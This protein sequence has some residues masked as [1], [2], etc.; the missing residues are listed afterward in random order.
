MRLILLFSGIV[1]TSPAWAAE[2][3]EC[4]QLPKPAV[5]LKLIESPI[6]INIDYGY[7]SLTTLGGEKVKPG[8]QVLGLTRINTVAHYALS[9]PAYL[10]SSRAY[11]CASPQ[12]AVTLGFNQMTVYVGKEFPKGSCAYNEIFEHEMRHVKTYQEHFASI[13]KGIQEEISRRFATGSIWRGQAGSSAARV[14]KELDERW[15]P[16]INR[17]IKK[18]ELAQ[19]LIDTPE[20]Y[21]RL[22]KAC[23]GEVQKLAK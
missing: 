14:G 3:N 1:A 8:G 7:R 15:L 16:Y 4:E 12:I 13:E 22:S 23:N 18:V 6:S 11:E 2:A 10:D 21:A 20:E 17:E 9:T 19:A 5:T